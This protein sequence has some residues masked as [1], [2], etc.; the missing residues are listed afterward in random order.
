MDYSF[1][2]IIQQ[3]NKIDSSH[4]KDEI[5]LRRTGE[6]F[7]LGSVCLLAQAEAALENAQQDNVD[8]TDTPIDNSFCQFLASLT[9]QSIS[10]T[11]LQRYLKPQSRVKY[12]RETFHKIQ[13]LTSSEAVGLFDLDLIEPQVISLAHDENINVW[14]QRVTKCLE[15]NIEISTLAQIAKATD[16]SIAQVFISLLFCN[17]ELL[18]SGDFYEGFT[19]EVRSRTS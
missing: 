14:V 2:A 18:Q 13:S 7:Y 1:S 17:F 19:I 15:S 3:V 8:L 5:K 9:Q 10:T 6:L 16:L 11:F 4:L 12:E